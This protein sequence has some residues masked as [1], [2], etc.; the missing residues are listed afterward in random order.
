MRRTT[1]I[2]VLALALFL[3]AASLPT[4]AGPLT[5]DA[6]PG[7]SSVE[8]WQTLGNDVLENLLFDQGSLWVSDGTA[9]AVL[10][11]DADGAVLGGLS[12]IPSPGGLAA[13]GD[14]LIYA[15]WGNSLANS[16][17][18]SGQAKVVRFNPTDPD[19]T[20]SV[21]AEGFNMPNGMTFLPDG[22]LAIS[23]DFDR[24]LLRIEQ[25]GS[26][27]EIASVW[28]T[29]GLVVSPDGEQLYAAVTF[30]Q[31]SP[32]ARVSLA[33]PSD[34]SYDI[35]LS[36][37]AASLEPTVHA[38]GDPGAP[39]LGVK[40]LDDMTRDDAGNL[41]VVANG[42]GELLRV[43]PSTGEACLVAGGLQNPS[44]VR[45]AP[46]QGAFA[47]GDPGTVDLYITEFSGIIRRVVAR[48]A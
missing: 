2:V 30:D 1:L 23:N 37:G 27:S 3:L 8:A 35:Q 28:G 9:S 34:V 10:R 15:G 48:A 36:F 6:C 18:R 47:D 46:E 11:L 43:D 14:G 12:G 39:L 42:T 22:A 33:D 7:S 32:I 17:T 13:G 40:G 19:G 21:F 41:Y 16:I 20:V 4:A 44:S 31:R 26:W 38:D 25:D 45:I 5:Q 29:N 24:G